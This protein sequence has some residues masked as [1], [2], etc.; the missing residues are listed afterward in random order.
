[1]KHDISQVSKMLS[2]KAEEVC[3]WLLPSGRRNGQEWCAGNVHGDAGDSLKVNIGGKAGVWRDFAADDKGG[4][5]IDL[6]MAC[7]GISKADA[8]KEARTYLGLKEDAKVEFIPQR[9]EYKKAVP[10]KGYKT[11]NGQ[12]LEYFK[13]RGISE[14]TVKA[15]KIAETESAILFPYIYE[16][17]LKFYK[18]RDKGKKEFWAAKDAEPVLFGWQAVTDDWRY[19]VITE[20]EMDALSFYEQGQPGLSVPFGGGDGDKQDKWLENE[21]ERLQLFDTIYLALDMDDQGRKATE[22]LVKRIGR[23]RCRVVNFGKYKDANEAHMDGARLV[24]FLTFAK[25]CDP[26]EL[27][28]ASDYVEEV[29]AFFNGNEDMSGYTLPWSKT[30][31]IIR[32]RPAEIS[33]WAGINGHG[34]SQALGHVTVGSIKQG[35]RWCIASME[36]KPYKLLARMYRQASGLAK[37]S[38]QLCRGD[39]YSYF[40]RSLFLFDIQGTAK[41]ERILEVFEYAYRRYGCTSFLVD[42]LAKCGFG[43]DE[44]NAQKKFVDLLM[45]FSQRNDVHVHLVC[46]ARKQKNEDEAPG[47]MDIKGTGALTD[48]VDNVFT[49]WRNKKKEQAMKEPGHK[50]KVY[51]E[52]DCLLEC[53]KQRHGEWEGRVQLWFDDASLQYKGER[54]HTA[55]CYVAETGEEYA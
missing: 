44:Y 50:Q 20:G 1:M 42:S 27:R 14:A 51:D 37:P 45:E 33:L 55:R 18:C 8:V 48:M 10:P 15:Y 13:S 28:S 4:D 24:D 19:V 49:V 40:D 43:E 35:E 7:L 38:D 22:H 36:L 54:E 23:H 16:G 2:A 30:N 26:P 17:D 46:H 3:R 29:I 25:S 9:R 53:S 5:L 12:V 31:N 39:I 41:A 34:K 21:Y 6:I 47:K 11:A 32:M 52:P